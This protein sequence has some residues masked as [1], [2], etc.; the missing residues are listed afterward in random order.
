MTIGTAGNRVSFH[1]DGVTKVFPVP[2]QAYLATDFDVLLTSSTGAETLLTLNS[3]FTLAAT[4][5]LQPQ[6]W[7]LTTSAAAAYA[8]GFVLQVL[9]NPDQ[10][11]QTQFVQGQ[12]FPSLAVQ[13]AFD[14]LTQ[15]AQRLQDQISRTLLAPDG[16]VNPMMGLPIAQQRANTYQTYDALGNVSMAV[17]LV[18]GTTLS[19]ASIGAF[20]GPATTAEL[21][22][23]A[24]VIAPWLPFGNLQRFGLVANNA[25]SAAANST[26]LAALFNPSIASGPTG[27]FFFPNNGSGSPDIYYFSNTP[28]Q[29][30][31]GITLD[32]NG[33]ILNFSG[34][35]NTAM[36][37]YGF[38]TAIRDVTI[39]N[40]TIQINYNGTGGTNNGNGIRIGSR[41]GYPFGTYSAGIFDQDDLL[42]NGKPLQG[43]VTIQNIRISS[44]NPATTTSAIILALGG[45]RNF[46]MK[47]VWI[48]GQSAV[49][50]NG[51]YYEY[52]WSSTNGTPG[53][54][55]LW[56][57]S[58][59]TA[60]SFKN[61]TISNMA[62]GGAS[63][64]FG[65]NGAYGC[66]L[67]DINIITADQ[68]MNFGAGESFFYRT[69]AL[70]GV[71]QRM[72]VLK[73]ITVKSC[74]IGITMGGA[75]PISGY[76]SAILNALA[77]PAKYQAQ[78]D[79]LNFSLDGFSLSTP[80]GTAII[81]SGAEVAIR[82]GACN[83]GGICLSGEAIRS[84][85]ENVQI[86]SA[87]GPNG[88]RYD[89]PSPATIWSPARPVFTAVRNCKIT[90]SSGVGIALGACQSAII[91]NNQIGASLVY[92]LAAEAT[93]TNG[94]N[95]AATSFG[96]RCR[97]NFI[98]TS[99][100]A[101]AY[102]NVNSTN[103]SNNSIE[104]ELNL[105]N[106]GA[107]VGG[108]TGGGG[109][110]LTDF[111][112]TSAQSI[113]SSG[114]ILLQN[115]RTVR[116][117]TAGAVTG[118]IMAAGYANGQTIYLVNESGNSITFAA[119]GTSRVAA[120]VSAVLASLTKMV[121][122]WDSVTGFWY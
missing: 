93:Q 9:V 6:A 87:S 75:Q 98:T 121:L 101:V 72:L 109:Q 118:V 40:G 38:L 50:G 59:M 11:Q 41:S 74:T 24:T 96:V 68:G 2:L 88:I 21:A 105:A 10:T 56:T 15:M 35:F 120:G 76:L 70:D 111:Q 79:F 85:I 54:Q 82:N 100:G 32:L 77:T 99:G 22:T 112:S 95:L 4:G 45:L 48:D 13:T 67:E 31:D 64:G 33:C 80:S 122:V 106:L 73:D 110:W 61:I 29:I 115:I 43:G 12:A 17:G 90:N 62:T 26:I 14:R 60:S 39:Q 97:N 119:S 46:T 1:C 86:L 63:Q 91:E 3:D 65:M 30:R 57:S 8:S 5:T 117:T 42:A 66:T 16:D 92:D 53:T 114:T 37:T 84:T 102:Q 51:F 20:T 94:V 55:N 104:T 81:A 52:G 103:G 34:A 71:T 113:A 83:G 28:I 58:H 7:T 23:G 27:L 49:K 69:W 107:I 108:V 116:L 19:A 78:T 18:A 36:N 47:N 89:F 25:G 44:N